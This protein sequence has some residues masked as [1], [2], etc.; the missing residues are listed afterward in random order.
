MRI[1][2]IVGVSALAALVLLAGCS[3]PE[4]PNVLLITIDTTRADYLG[5]YGM[6]D[7]H[8]PVMDGLAAAGVQFL[9]N[10]APSQCTNPSHASILTGLYPVNHGVYNNRSAL[11]SHAVTLAE[12]LGEK[13]YATLGAVS[14]H[15]LNPGNSAFDQGFDQYLECPSRNITAGQRNETLFP[16]LRELGE[17]PFL[18]WVHYFDPHG[19]YDPPAPYDTLH[20]R[21]DIHDSLASGQAMNIAAAKNPGTMIDPDEHIALYRGEISYLD[22]QI[23]ELLATLEAMGE[24]ENTLVV[25]VADHGE[26]MTEKNIYF[27]HAGLYNP[28]IHVPLIMRWPSELPAG[29]KVAGLTSSVDVLPTILDLVGVDRDV[30]GLSGRTLMP[31]L[32]DGEFEVH[33]MVI[34]EAVDGVIRGIQQGEYRYITPVKREWSMPTDHLFRSFIDHAEEIDLKD[35]EPVRATDMARLLDERLAAEG[36]R[37]LPSTD[38]T[39]LDPK[40]AEALK[41]LGYIN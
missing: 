21:T 37:V 40:T 34:S 1:R 17:T 7:A 18:A 6:E 38:E 10:M 33:D 5:C 4:P 28:V 27:S 25:L 41:S 13:G 9:H 22:A 26:S 14:A 32:V 24:A 39:A 8:T 16:A 31:T 2:T 35:T 12:I 23:G 36:E 29:H 3:R 15:H 19:V 11:S 30:S 20:P